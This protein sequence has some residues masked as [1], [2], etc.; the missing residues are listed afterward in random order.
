MT[1]LQQVDQSFAVRDPNLQ[2]EIQAWQQTLMQKVQKQLSSIF[3]NH[4]GALLN[5][6]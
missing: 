2:N 6:H 3:E 4:Y 1:E 5:N